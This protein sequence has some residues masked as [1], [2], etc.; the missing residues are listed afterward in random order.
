MPLLKS[1]MWLSL[2]FTFLAAPALAAPPPGGM[3]TMEQTID[4][5]CAHSTTAVVAQVMQLTKNFKPGRE[6]RVGRIK[7]V[8][9]LK[10]NPRHVPTRI[11]HGFSVPLLTDSSP[12]FLEKGGTYL[13]FIKD[14]PVKYTET[15]DL[16]GYRESDRQKW[17]A[18]AT[19]SC[20]SPGAR[21]SP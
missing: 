9:P 7:V 5:G 18:H 1:P 8:A 14:R 20:A 2:A 6:E 12:V 4:L 10:G 17:I 21:Y 19:K 15:V 16:T 13:V 11:T 3:P